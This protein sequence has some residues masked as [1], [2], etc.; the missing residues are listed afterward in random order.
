MVQIDK[1]N[2]ESPP[3]K[4]SKPVAIK[5]EIL[6]GTQIIAKVEET[7]GFSI[8][9][10]VLLEPIEGEFKHIV[11]QYVD[12]ST[13]YGVGYKLSNGQYGVL[14][15]DSTKIVLDHNQFHFDYIQKPTSPSGINQN[16]YYLT[17]DGDEMQHF[18]FFTYP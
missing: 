9:V 6:G 8:P 16:E 18:N 17:S 13:K 12:Y 5:E 10:N 4:K 1:E 15:N 7:M 3:P 14:F 2:Q 11:V